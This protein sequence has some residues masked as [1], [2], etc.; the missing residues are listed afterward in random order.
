[1]HIFESVPKI[2]INHSFLTY[3]YFQCL[4]VHV[5]LMN[6]IYV[7][8]LMMYCNDVRIIYIHNIVNI[9]RIINE[10]LEFIA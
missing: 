9:V 4:S 7:I 2:N 1:M 6:G 8:S 5:Y 3:I 10:I